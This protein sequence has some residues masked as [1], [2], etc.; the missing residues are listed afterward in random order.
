MVSLLT[1]HTAAEKLGVPVSKI[2]ALVRERKIPFIKLP[3]EGNKPS[4][5]IRFREDELRAWVESLTEGGGH[6]C[7]STSC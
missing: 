1:R 3:A 4:R 2:D 7:G 6:A 5:Y